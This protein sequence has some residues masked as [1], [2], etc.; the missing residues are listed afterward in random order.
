MEKIKKE[1]LKK[2]LSRKELS[3]TPTYS[4]FKKIGIKDHHGFCIPL[5]SIRSKK[6]SGIGEFN[7]LT[8]LISW[9]NEI[10]MDTIQLLPLNE[11]YYKDPSPYNSLSSCALDYIYLTLDI[12]PYHEKN[13]YLQELIEKLRKLNSTKRVKF[14]KVRKLKITWLFEYYKTYFSKYKE[15]ESYTS[16]T[17]KN[18]WL[19]PYSTFRT[20]KNKFK[21][22][23]W[24]KWPKK[25][26]N[27]TE[28]FI[29]N[30][31]N[32]NQIDTDFFIF[33]QYLCFTQLSNV[34][35]Y[36][37]KKKVLLK[38]DIP[39]LI[40]PDSADV[41]YY[42][43]VFNM[44]K[45]AGA[46]PDDFN[47]KG[48]KWGFPIFDWDYLKET[49]YFWWK[50]K[51]SVIS[52]L[53]HIYRIDHAVGFFRIWAI[54]LKDKPSLGQFLP[55]DPSKWKDI[56]EEHFM[57]LINASYQLPIA[58][59]L[60]FIPKI[61]YTSLKKLGICG[62]KVP[63]WQRT[64]KMCDYEPISLTTIS[65]HDTET[66]Q[67]WW[68]SSKE[69]AQTLCFTNNW[70]YTPTL[71]FELR[72]KILYDS[73]HSASIFHINLLQEYLALYPELVWKNPKDERINIS[74]CINKKNW[75]YK[76]RLTI[77]EIISHSDLKK[78]L[79]EITSFEL[80]SNKI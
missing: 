68:K 21:G 80:T 65:T 72:K 60:G 5:S 22:K 17:N 53:Y 25:Y 42:R 46:P 62:T 15:L 41:W 74:G 45:I 52:D 56:G 29:N 23:K 12:L 16:F 70:E 33:L 26:Q 34:K 32:S 76:Y 4:L 14:D 27:P 10:K 77:E 36:A 59:D 6:S 40:N 2:E 39:I 51:L 30:Y 19:K 69:E 61:V 13:I 49:D 58:E 38:G 8:Y 47:S 67:Q 31:I 1:L 44:D 11:T 63:R 18:Q 9:C 66:M 79:S 48:H 54:G 28:E 3:N 43:A 57:M 50:Q 64:T 78:T 71:S 55:K 35:D 24:W 37:T 20:L 73:H 75:R 7:D